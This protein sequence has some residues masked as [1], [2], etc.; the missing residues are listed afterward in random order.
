MATTQRYN[1]TAGKIKVTFKVSKQAAQGADKIFLLC[2]HNGWD[3]L[4][5]SA[6][7]SGDF[8]IDVEFDPANEQ[9]D[10]QYR[11]QLFMAD[12]QTKYD[13]DWEADAY[14]PNIFGEDNSLVKINKDLVNASQDAEEAEKPAKAA[15]TTKKCACKTADAKPKATKAKK[16]K[17]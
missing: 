17:E 5:L 7:K 10:F 15:K 11:Y 9:T 12:G 1:K 6:Q 2:E 8:K 14:V 3:P 16:S 13:N 4:E